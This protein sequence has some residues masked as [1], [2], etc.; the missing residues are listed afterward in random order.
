MQG[1]S[2]IDKCTFEAESKIAMGAP[3]FKL[4]T[5]DANAF[6]FQWAEWEAGV[7]TAKT[8]LADIANT[9]PFFAG[10]LPKG[11]WP[12]PIAS[13]AIDGTATHAT[14]VS[15]STVLPITD[16]NPDMD[17]FVASPGKVAWYP[18]EAGTQKKTAYSTMDFMQ[19]KADYDAYNTQV[20]TYN[21][22]KDEYNTKKDA[23]NKALSDEAARMKD[24]F[25]SIFEP[26][27]VIPERPCQPTRLAAFD[28]VELKYAA[29]AAL[30]DAEKTA[31]TGTFAQNGMLQ[32]AA[33]SYKVGYQVANAD[34]TA[35]T[36]AA[37]AGH[38]YGLFGQGTAQTDAATLPFQWKLADPAVAHYMM[39]SIL[40]SS[41]AGISAL[42]ASKK[43]EI[44]WTAKA[45]GTAYASVAKPSQ[46]DATVAPD[47]A[48]AK[49]LA[50]SAVAVAAVAASLF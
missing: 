3:S 9:T 28:G 14:L 33:A 19:L 35:T 24:F 32:A 22:D 27:I 44:T 46:P 13:F 48:S 4:T 2:S 43:I 18:S 34:A 30:T 16:Y 37:G 29:T 21:T 49:A 11:Q 41:A 5:A 45:F 26:A 47:S 50:A 23:Y 6:Q 12:N 36:L 8:Q 25:K 1:F 10:T 15:G 31:K 42:A 17:G 39:V 40:P 20:S 7:L 38:T